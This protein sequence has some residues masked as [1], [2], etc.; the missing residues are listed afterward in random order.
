MN[1]IPR[2][3][4][5]RLGPPPFPDCR[6]VL[7]CR[8]TGLSSAK[9]ARIA[10]FTMSIRA[11]ISELSAGIRNGRESYLARDANYLSEAK[12]TGRVVLS[13]APAFGKPSRCS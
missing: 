8:E 6:G 13:C 4:S 5:E 12:A 7:P 11:A 9:A 3:R 10:A 2:T 1:P